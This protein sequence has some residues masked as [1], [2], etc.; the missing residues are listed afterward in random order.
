MRGG[1]DADRVGA[2]GVERH[3]AER[4]LAVEPQQHVEADADDR[5]QPDRGDDENLIAVTARDEEAD[6]GNRDGGRGG[7]APAH[8]FLNA[9]RPNRPFGRTASARITSAK[10]DD[11]GVGRANSAV[12]SASATP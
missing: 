2:D 4:N 1:Q 8:T 3:M 5:G 6:D 7:R 12:I 10:G 9:A 11:L